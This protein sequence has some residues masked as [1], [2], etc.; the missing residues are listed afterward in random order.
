V[1]VSPIRPYPILPY[2]PELRPNA[3]A[4]PRRTGL[5]PAVNA[6]APGY[7][8]PGSS[9]GPR[10]LLRRRASGREPSVARTTA[11]ATPG[12]GR[13]ATASGPS[14]G[15]GAT[16]GGPVAQRSGS[17][18]RLARLPAVGV[19]RSSRACTVVG[20]GGAHALTPG[21]YTTA[22]GLFAIQPGTAHADTLSTGRTLAGGF[23]RPVLHIPSEP[24]CKSTDSR[25][26]APVL[27][28]APGIRQF[29][30]PPC[31]E[32]AGTAFRN[33]RGPGLILNIPDAP[34]TVTL[35]YIGFKGF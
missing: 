9:P 30:Q 3:L 16:T 32:S 7:H 33:P 15:G 10:W 29:R 27:H 21:S 4:V 12:A 35:L 6:C 13:S 19:E 11:R 22:N 17:L 24:L 20:V 8:L 1:A 23:L 14:A 25:F 2:Q 34:I 5:L 28:T 26:R 31:S 18:F